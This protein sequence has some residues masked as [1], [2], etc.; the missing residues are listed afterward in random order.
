MSLTGANAVLMLS[1]PGLFDTPQQLQGF[2][3]DDIFD[4]EQV[5]R[6]ETLMGV[7]GTLSAGYVFNER[8]MTITLQSD[9]PSNRIFE[10]WDSAETPPYGDILYANMTVVLTGL[11]TKWSCVKGF[12]SDQ[13]PGGLAAVKKLV[14]PRKYTL[15]WES[16]IPQRS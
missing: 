8:V 2:A 11:Q 6:V 4:V 7:D 1:V 10:E 3:A 13:P 16:I 9:S 12:W 14:Q 15:R 5:K